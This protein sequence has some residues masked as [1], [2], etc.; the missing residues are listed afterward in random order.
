MNQNGEMMFGCL[1]RSSIAEHFQTMETNDFI[2]ESLIQHPFFIARS[3]DIQCVNFDD[4]FFTQ[5]LFLSILHILL[6]IK[7]NSFS[8]Q[9]VSA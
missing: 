3:S 9:L 7:F 1:L 6:Q 4:V 2:L 5:S 8:Q